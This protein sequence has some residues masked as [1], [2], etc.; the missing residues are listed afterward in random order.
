[1]NNKVHSSFFVLTGLI[2]CVVYILVA[3]KPLGKEIQF[4]PE[5][6]IDVTNPSI[7]KDAESEA[8]LPF[9]LGQ[10]LGYFTPEGEVTNFIT[11]PQND[12]HFFSKTIARKS[13]PLITPSS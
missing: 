6:K 2:F 10:T 5:W 1:M 4:V 11:F 8:L 3:V 7:A 9:K 13:Y 12:G